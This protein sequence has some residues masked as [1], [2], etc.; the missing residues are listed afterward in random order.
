[1]TENTK[2]TPDTLKRMKGL[3]IQSAARAV[4][5]RLCAYTE[6]K[7]W[8]ETEEVQDREITAVVTDSR[9][10]GRDCLFAAIRGQRV[11]GHSFIPQCAA[12]GAAVILAEELPGEGLDIPVILTDDTLRALRDLAEYYLAVLQIPA[13]GIIGSV[14]KTSTKEVTAAVLGRKFRVLKTEGNFNNELGVPLTIFR[15]RE[16]DEL[17]VLEMGINHFGEMTRLAK[18]VRPRAVIMTN[19]GFSHIEFLGSQEGILRAKSEA[20]AYLSPDGCA[21]LNADDPLLASLEKRDDLRKVFYGI[22]P[23]VSGGPARQIWADALEPQG[24]KGTR[25]VIHTPDGAIPVLVPVPGRHMVSNA[26]AAAAAGWVFGLSGEQIAE[27]VSRME[28]LT[29]RFHLMETGTLTIIDDSYNASPASV[30]AALDL[31]REASGRKVAVLG[32]MGELG[33]AAPSLHAE[34][35]AFAAEQGRCDALYCVG[36]ISRQMAEAASGK[37]PALCVKWFPDRDGLLEQ[38]GELFRQGDTVLVKA[39]HF[40]QFE[41]VVEALG[42]ISL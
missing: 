35:G 27:G 7:G 23:A 8:H 34:V 15:L 2:Q 1:M 3:T 33:E 18:I 41:K 6:E 40:M 12:A 25:C 31:L 24:L 11:D 16:E 42:Q 36:E 29:G 39:S 17:A 21:I 14:G 10:A 28:T 22:G 26:L 32:D 20:F 30:E 37:N 13:V 38:A 4:R 19:I 5:G 9:K